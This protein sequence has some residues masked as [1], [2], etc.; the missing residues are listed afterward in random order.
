MS[1]SGK[2][3]ASQACIRGFRVPSPAPRTFERC[4][5]GK[6]SA[7][8]FC[9]RAINSQKSRSRFTMEDGRARHCVRAVRRPNRLHRF[10]EG[11]THGRRARKR[12]DDPGRAGLPR[13]AAHVAALGST[14][15][16]STLT[17]RCST[18]C[19]SRRA[20]ERGAGRAGIPQPHAGRDPQL[21]GRARRRSSASP[22]L[23]RRR[24]SRPTPPC[25]VGKSCIR[26]SATS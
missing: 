3:Q 1:P 18:R 15:S 22:S 5:N 19:R 4:R 12:Q 6:P 26:S 20:H 13:R 14:R 11:T 10:R 21:R 9:I 17:A 7:A 23:L 8:L 2:A 16:S 24:P 25:A